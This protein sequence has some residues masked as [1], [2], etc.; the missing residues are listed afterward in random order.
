MAG[1]NE[2]VETAFSF[3]KDLLPNGVVRYT[4][5]T[6]STSLNQANC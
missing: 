2:A 4:G 1:G 6:K 3:A 5:I